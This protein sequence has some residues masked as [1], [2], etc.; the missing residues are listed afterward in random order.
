MPKPPP[1]DEL[2]LQ[3][4]KLYYKE[5]LDQSQVAHR[6][7]VSR[8][9]VSRLLSEARRKGLVEIHVNYPLATS[10]ELE[11]RLTESFSLH[12]AHVLETNELADQVVLARLGMLGARVLRANLRPGDSL[13][14]GWGSG[15]H[16]TVSAV[17][18]DPSVRARVIQLVGG[19][20]S[21]NSEID[22]G[23]LARRLA[24]KLG[25]EYLAL[26]APLIVSPDVAAVL[27]HEPSVRDVLALAA[28]ARVALVGVGT[29]DP[30]HSG[31]L[32][33][34]L[35]TEAQLRELAAKQIVGDICCHH[36][37]IGGQVAD[38][39]LNQRVVGIQAEALRAIPLVIAVAGGL[40]KAP[41]ILG[42]LRGNFVKI[43]VTDEHAA[44]EVLRLD[45][46]TR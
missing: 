14:V 30:Q 44:R 4:A 27:L 11:D 24:E 13:G 42:A 21:G 2:I 37:D 29:V 20:G 6:I 34:G 15:V 41:A 9:Y 23:E 28:G 1:S 39:E 25:G 22:S 43:L 38:A 8:S 17:E 40:G 18:P 45:S 3:A 26:R 31:L 5:G 19:L 46:F 16:A 12:R 35:M 10:Q 36:I 33:A 32:R 7:G